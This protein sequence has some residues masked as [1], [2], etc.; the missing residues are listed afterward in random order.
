MSTVN[1]MQFFVFFLIFPIIESNVLLRAIHLGLPPDTTGAS[2][3]NEV[4]YKMQVVWFPF[5]Q[6]NQ[7]LNIKNLNKHVYFNSPNYWQYS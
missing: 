2:A 1:K 3:A 6:I 7:N 4:A 5:Y